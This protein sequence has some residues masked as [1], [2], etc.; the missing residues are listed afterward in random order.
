MGVCLAGCIKKGLPNPNEPGN[1][2]SEIFSD[3]SEINSELPSGNTE[4]H[5]MNYYGIDTSKLDDYTFASCTDPTRTDSV[6]LMKLKD[7]ADTEEIKDSLNLL[8]EQMG[9][10]MENYNPAANELVK[11]ASVRVNGNMI[12][13]IICEDIDKALSITEG[14][15][16]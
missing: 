9:A 5:I 13:L 6:I 12:V 10:E 15:S 7:E 11:K 8:L 2:T 16:N 1:Y 4:E 3:S 14:S